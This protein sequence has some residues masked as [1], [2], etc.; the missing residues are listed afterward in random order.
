MLDLLGSIR[1]MQMHQHKAEVHRPAC[2]QLL[3]T[4]VHTA[5]ETEQPHRESLHGDVAPAATIVS[6]LQLNVVQDELM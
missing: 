6:Q 4:E 1:L 3:A 2:K 5:A